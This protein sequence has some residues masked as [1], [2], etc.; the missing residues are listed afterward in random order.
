MVKNLVKNAVRKSEKYPCTHARNLSFRVVAVM[1]LSAILH[2]PE[3][4]HQFPASH[5]NK[6]MPLRVGTVLGNILTGSI[7]CGEMWGSIHSLGTFPLHT[8]R[9]GEQPHP[10]AA[11]GI[12]RL[13]CL[14][15]LGIVLGKNEGLR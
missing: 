15:V 1:G 9:Q 6:V 5:A 10:A 14:S 2:E 4:F 7:W 12:S 8:S 11:L 3:K 13:L